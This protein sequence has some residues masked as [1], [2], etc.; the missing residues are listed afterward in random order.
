MAGLGRA[1]ALSGATP[2]SP[3]SPG[4]SPATAGSPPTSPTSPTSPTRTTRTS[5]GAC[6][7]RGKPGPARHRR[8]CCRP[9]GNPVPESPWFGQLPIGHHSL[10]QTELPLLVLFVPPRWPLCSI[11]RPRCVPSALGGRVQPWRGTAPLA[12]LLCAVVHFPLPPP[13]P[14][15]CPIRFFCLRMPPGRAPL[16]VHTA[17]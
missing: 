6:R 15:R 3:S 9:R 16:H 10:N 11:G 2:G 8:P 12:R 17:K 14:S 4:T 1:G 5:G 7:A 13:T